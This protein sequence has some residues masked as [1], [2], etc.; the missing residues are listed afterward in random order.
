MYLVVLI[1]AVLIVRVLF[2]TF[3]IN[4]EKISAAQMQLA[5]IVWLQKFRHHAL[6][7]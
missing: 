4:Q 5:T 3:T 2:T 6:V 1:Q 7:T